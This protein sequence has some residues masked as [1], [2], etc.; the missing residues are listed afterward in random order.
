MTIQLA[1]GQD[2]QLISSEVPLDYI[3]VHF[4][5]SEP[6]VFATSQGDPIGDVILSKELPSLTQALDELKDA[7]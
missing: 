3:E 4:K 6:P 5:E 1:F 7:N 2:Y